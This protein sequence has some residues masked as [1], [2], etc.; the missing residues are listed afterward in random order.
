MAVQAVVQS[1][2][3]KSKLLLRKTLGA[4]S[5]CFKL[6]EAYFVERDNKIFLEKECCTKDSG[7]IEND[8][9]FF[10]DTK[11]NV[12]FFYEDSGLPLGHDIRSEEVKQK[13]RNDASLYCL[14][15]NMKCNLKC[16]ICYLNL[17]PKSPEMY[18]ET[19]EEPSLEVIKNLLKGQKRK[20]VGL[21]GGEPTL[22]K[23]IT[24]IIR[25]IKKSGNT[26]TMST[27]GLTLLDKSFLKELKEAGLVQVYL[28]FDSFHDEVYEKLRGGRFL[29][30]RFKIL[31]NLKEEK[32]SVCLTPVIAKGVND[33]EIPN[34]LRFAMKNRAFIRAINFVPFYSGY[35][36]FPESA[37]TSDILNVLE[38]HFGIGK[39][40]WIQNDKFRHYINY[41]VKMLLG[42]SFGD[43]FDNMKRNTIHLIEKE[44]K[45]I[46]YFSLYEI[47]EFN[48]QADITM[49]KNGLMKMFSAFS[50]IVKLAFKPK[51]LSFM[52]TLLLNKFDSTK[53]G[54]YLNNKFLTLRISQICSALNHDYGRKSS[55]AELQVVMCRVE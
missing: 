38:P 2:D 41:F 29:A 40:Y 7:L 26:P 48:K 11:S 53:A 33:H 1:E 44:G 54:H 46:P 28:W 8:A 21:I 15:I 19:F 39:E 9:Q 31:K 5:K 17:G 14:T 32:I 34:L 16:P 55:S 12:N 10:K 35:E 37:T 50:L 43:R 22:R 3:T 25:F 42:N 30:S 51:M 45:I 23:D 49:N 4:C 6:T 47:K 52:K 13:M 20:L 36:I 27:H 18:E 24:D